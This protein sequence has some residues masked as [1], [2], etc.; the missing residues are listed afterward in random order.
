MHE[1]DVKGT[2]YA[3]QGVLERPI[4][5]VLQMSWTIFYTSLF[6]FVRTTKI[7]MQKKLLLREKERD[8]E[9]FLFQGLLLL[10]KSKMR[11]WTRRRLFLA[12]KIIWWDFKLGVAIAVLIQI[13]RMSMG[14]ID[15]EHSLDSQCL[16]FSLGVEA[17]R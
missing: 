13:L 6:F 14:F 11:C 1:H 4:G 8:R 17:G 3:L 7:F 16:K 5:I 2:P 9:C 12:W 15:A 10:M